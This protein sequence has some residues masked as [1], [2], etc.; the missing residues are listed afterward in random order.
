[1][2]P[3]RVELTEFSDKRD[4]CKRLISG[5]KSSFVRDLDELRDLRDQLA[6]A[7]TFVEGSDGRMGVVA[8]VE[9]FEAAKR[10]TDT[11]MQLAAKGTATS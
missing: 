3:P 4:L 2:N 8:F 5:S 11:L 10:W 1:M 9:K 6:H 7:T